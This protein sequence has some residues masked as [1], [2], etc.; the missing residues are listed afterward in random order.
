M[1]AT[2]I[3]TRIPRSTSFLPPIPQ[4]VPFAPGASCLPSGTS[5]RSYAS[6]NESRTQ[7]AISSVSG[8]AAQVSAKVGE[9]AAA[10]TRFVSNEKGE[11]H[12]KR[13]REPLDAQG[14]TPGDVVPSTNLYI[15]NLFFEVS[16]STLQREFEKYG[17]VT[18]VRII[19]DDRGMSR[20]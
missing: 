4:L 19:T 18:R 6:D 8:A 11:T 7:S 3:L 15:G 5:F 13:Q 14:A 17:N 9:A 16:E 1:S 20:G 12:Q 2:T 10:A